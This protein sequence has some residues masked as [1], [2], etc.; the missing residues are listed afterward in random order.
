MYSR[1]ALL[2][3]VTGAALAVGQV[4]P[5]P[6]AAAVTYDQA[7]KTGFVDGGDLR[8]AFG[9][10]DAVLAQRAAGV[11]F[12]EEFWTNDTYSVT[13]GGAAFPVVHHRVFGRFGLGD[14]VVR[15]GYGGPPAGFRLTGARAGI[16]GTSVPPAPGQPCPEE[17]GPAID[18][19]TLVSTTTGWALTAGSDGVRRELTRG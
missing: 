15:D 17:K 10:T 1:G 12:D 6:A 5:A 9:W 13:C 2:L 4:L 3:T 18:K 19:V 11:V 7:A 14:V 16:S 8:A